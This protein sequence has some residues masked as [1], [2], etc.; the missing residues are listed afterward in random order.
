MKISIITVC[1]NSACTIRDT[2]ESVLNQDYADVEYI[3]IDGYSSDSTLQIISEYR[4]RIAYLS[5]ETDKGLYDAMNKGVLA[6]SGDII[7]ILNSDD[8]YESNMVLSYV[9]ACFTEN[10]NTDLVF[11][12]VVIVKP[13]QTSIVKRHYSASHFRRWK[14]RFGWMPPHPATFIRKQ[15]Y[16][17]VGF[18]SL[19]YK[20]ASDFEF[21][22]R[23]LSVNHLKFTYMDKVLVRMRLGGVSS[24]G[25]N[26][27]ILLNFEIVKACR[28]N[29]IY[30]NI[31]MVLTK[32]PFKLL[33]FFRKPTSQNT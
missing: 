17:K 29:G 20:I 10:L 3:I 24:A 6:A 12:D 18:Y 23:M 11:G 31:L 30:T 15:A 28:S 4:D 19:N 7:G 5:S 21:F 27:K 16:K 33:E 26:S 14:L 32:V 9:A 13:S 8:F 22:V 1:Y 25:V 2:I